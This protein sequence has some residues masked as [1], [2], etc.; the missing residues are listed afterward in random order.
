MTEEESKQLEKA[1]AENSE[2]TKSSDIQHPKE[3]VL[4]KVLEGLPS[5]TMREIRSV[6]SMSMGRM[7]HPIVE[8][9]TPE[10]ITTILQHGN[11]QD[12]RDF[13]SA[14]YIR[15]YFFL[16]LVLFVVL[17]VFL[18]VYFVGQGKVDLYFKVLS[19]FGTFVAGLL[20]G[21]GGGSIVKD[22]LNRR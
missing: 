3:Q 13:Q 20:G 21:F 15:R 17:F 19:Y 8:K 18:T 7:S 1:N 22:Y 14:G 4:P 9:L 11:E 12:G 6:M 16:T 5:D 10:H 2:E